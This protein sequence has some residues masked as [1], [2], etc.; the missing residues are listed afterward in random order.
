MDNKGAIAALA[1]LAQ[2]TRLQVFRLLVSHAPVGL[3]AGQAATALGVPQNTL[4]SHLAIL[5]HAGLVRAE[6]QGRSIIY[7]AGLDTLGALMLF[8]ARDCCDAHPEL[9][10]P[11]LAELACCPS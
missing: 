6:R 9:C 11:L 3:P 1:A 4:S 10:S 7:R 8:L 5:A 2:P